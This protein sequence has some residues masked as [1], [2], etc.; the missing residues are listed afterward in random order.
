LARWLA[1]VAT[2][3]SVAS[4]DPATHEVANGLIMREGIGLD[5]DVAAGVRLHAGQGDDT[6]WWFSRARV[7]VLLIDEP[8]FWS[9]GIAGQ[10][11]PLAS[12]S[13]GVEL[14]YVEVYHGASVQLGVFPLDS[15]G[16]TTLEAQVGLTLVSLE[17]QR[18][19][20][21]PRDGDQA[22]VVELQVPLG[23]IYQMLKDPPGVVHH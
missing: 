11:G 3:G 15:I 4:A 17:Y 20:S 2:L 10:L 23:V 12:S 9:L 5:V 21:G 7:G 14:Q 19:V 1:L 13:L 6:R 8:S 22:L 16:G 18:R